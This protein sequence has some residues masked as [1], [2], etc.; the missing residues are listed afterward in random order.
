MGR[1]KLKEKAKQDLNGKYSEAIKVV[2]IMG[3]INFG[4]TFFIS[5]LETLGLNAPASSIF[6]SFSSFIVSALLELGNLSFYLKISR[7]E[8]TS[9]KELFSKTKLFMPYIAITVLT[10]VFVMLW[11]I[12]FI[13]PGIIAA[14]GYS[15]VNYII[16]DNPNMEA[17]EVLK[18]SKKLMN[19]HK[20]EFF[21]LQLSFIGW[22]L[23]AAC[24]FGLLYFYV[25][26]YI[27]VTT[28]NYYNYLKDNSENI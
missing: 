24:T 11:S 20:W 14:V 17:M 19:G 25:I 27:N 21:C 4:I 22:H 9:Y 8:E 6:T 3:I 2:L 10:A 12:L 28:A 16:I 15:M 1:K 5:L 23:L 13:I 26:P 7:N 18:Q